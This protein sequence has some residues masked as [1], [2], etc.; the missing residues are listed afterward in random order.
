MRRPMS[1][2]AYSAGPAIG[3]GYE[4]SL[5]RNQSQSYRVLKSQPPEPIAPRFIERGSAADANIFPA[6]LS[7]STRPPE[8]AAFLTMD[9]EIARASSTFSDALS[10]GNVE[11]QKLTDVVAASDVERVLGHHR[12]IHEEQ[13]RRDP[14]YL[15][16]IFGKE[17]EN[18]VIQAL[19]FSPEEMARYSLDRQDYL[20]FTTKEGQHRPYPVRMG[21]AKQD[22]IYFVVL[23]LNLAVRAL[24]PPTPSPNP[25]DMTYS[26]QP[27]PQPYSHPT[28]VSAT[29]D[30]RH[31]RPSEA[32]YGSRRSSLQQPGA[33]GQMISGLSPG[34]A[35]PFAASPNRQDYPGQTS[36]Q[37]PRSDLAPTTTAT[38]RPPQMQG[39]QLPPI[40]SQ[41]QQ[42]QQQQP[43]PPP[44]GSQSSDQSQQGRDDRRRVGIGGLIEQPDPSNRPR[45]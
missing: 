20:T 44:T 34:Y 32:G 22:S 31:Q 37:A 7:I 36:Y 28:P 27:M 19:G 6:P 24:Q 17:T 29:F 26:Y 18:R 30:P 5:R 21:L 12:Q 35:A 25:R 13:Q 39:Y 38:S 1:L 4:D 33:Q 40:I 9:F 10:R 15:P 16:P 23:T 11:G 14:S 43:P 2:S 42:Q 3:M 45:S 41:Q 8:P